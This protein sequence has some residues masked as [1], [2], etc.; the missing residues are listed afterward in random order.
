MPFQPAERLQ[1]LPPYLFVA[2]D[3]KRRDAIAA[4]KDVINL[5]VG[6]PDQPTHA[7]I[8]ERMRAR[9]AEPANHCYPS[10]I[11][12]AAFREQ[13]V[14]FF[15][16]RYGV[17]LDAASEVR[18]LI[19]TKEGLGH[20]PLAVINPGRTALIPEPGYPVYLSGTIFA[21]GRPYIMPLTEDRR[22]LPDLEAIPSD[23]AR[24][25][26]LLYLNYPNNPTGAAADLDFYRQAVDFARQNDLIVVQDAAYN[27]MYFEQQPP[28]ILQVPGAKDVAIE[29]HS[30]SKT[31]NMTGWR[32]G[33]AAGNADVLAALS[34]IK[35][36]MDS[37]Q[38][39]AIQEAGAAALAGIDRPELHGS[40]AMYQQR[41]D[42][43]VA[44][45]RKI[46]FH[47][48]P[49]PAT[50][51]IWAGVPGGLDS[52]TV[53]NRMIEEAA[54]VGVP[55]IGFGKACD[56]YVRFALTVDVERIHQAVTRL[57]EIQW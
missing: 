48:E 49:P 37:G 38:F 35:A 43:M 3:R 41:R 54:V 47:V 29:L 18:T 53:V 1:A 15:A 33:F 32:L 12:A 21:G 5:G 42:A 14:A 24:D 6:D 23:T 10:N 13:A 44:G 31:F 36:N 11:G 34:K 2:I 8:I 45:L 7:F 28:S 26:V 19:G 27:E 55:G 4:G 56:G 16:R 39:T 9:I 17:E 57:A 40:R 51:Y 46:G 50:F 52:M 30:L 25:A 22:W 20:L